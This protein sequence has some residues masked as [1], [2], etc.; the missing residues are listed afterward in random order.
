MPEMNF[1]EFMHTNIRGGGKNKFLK[2]WKKEP[3]FSITIW[4]HTKAGIRKLNRHRF[5][6]LNVQE[7]ESGGVKSAKIEVW[8]SNPTCLESAEVIKKQNYRDKETGRRDLPPVLCP[9]CKMID[10]VYMLIREGKLDWRQPIFKFEGNQPA[11]KYNTQIIHAGGLCGLFG[12]SKMT[13]AQK[14]Q[15]SQTPPEWGAI[16]LSEAWREDIRTKSEYALT[17]VDENAPGEGLQVT[18]EPGGVGE[19]IQDVVQK[20]IADLG[21]EK[22]DPMIH[23]YAIRLEANQG[24]SIGFGD[25]YDASKMGRIALRPQVEALIRGPF[26]DLSNLEA[27]FE[28]KTMMAR[29]ERH[30]Q[31]LINLP[32]AHYFKDALAEEERKKTAAPQKPQPPAM[33]PQVTTVN[34]PP[35]VPPMT[36]GTFSA[37]A[38]TTTPAPHVEEVPMVACDMGCGKAMR[39]DATVCPHCGY[40]YEVE[41]APPPPPA[42]LPKRSALVAAPAV[43]PAASLTPAAAP[44]PAVAA[45]AP[46]NEASSGGGGYPGD[47][48][49][50]IPF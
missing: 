30:S 5:P 49:D 26:S 24:D 46:P 45:F 4:L 6:R 20:A 17:I 28:L 32:W 29:F 1:K 2:S 31:G 25:K 50:D 48:S 35:P 11:S 47:P 14:L 10:H 7:V 43:A 16:Y 42:P 22:G 3:P 12:N 18:I 41:A 23:P 39:A 37:P 19:C 21:E 8:S 33:I 40:K 36:I 34:A 9:I 27:P 44:T 15:L 38:P 13:D